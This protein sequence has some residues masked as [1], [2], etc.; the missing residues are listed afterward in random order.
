MQVPRA[1]VI[2]WP[3]AAGHEVDFVLERQQQLLGVE[4][5]AGAHPTMKD[6]RGLRA[7]LEASIAKDLLTRIRSAARPP[8]STAR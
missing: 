6:V 8:L 2:Y 7:F 4:V 5:K 1:A 3:T